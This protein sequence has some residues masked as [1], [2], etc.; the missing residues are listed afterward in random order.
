MEMYKLYELADNW[1]SLAYEVLEPQYSETLNWDET[2]LDTLEAAWDH[3]QLWF[4]SKF[5]RHI[6]D[7]E[8]DFFSILIE[9]YYTIIKDECEDIYLHPITECY[10]NG[11]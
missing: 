11:L 2:L 7:K 10:R 1:Y 4:G 9:E 3:F 6:T 5:K 8:F